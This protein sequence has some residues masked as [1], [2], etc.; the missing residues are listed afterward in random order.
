LSSDRLAGVKQEVKKHEV[1]IEG[2]VV[3]PV[4]FGECADFQ[5]LVC[6]FFSWLF[7]VA[8]FSRIRWRANGKD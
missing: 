6:F 1:R 7:P 8:G 4:D 5:Y 2:D 3:N